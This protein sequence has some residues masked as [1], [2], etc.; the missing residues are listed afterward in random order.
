MK[1]VF[2][3]NDGVICL[4]KNWGSRF[5]KTKAYS[6][7]VFGL[8]GN[9]PV[10]FRFDNFDK[11]AIKVLNEILTETG[12]E[13]VVSSDWR[14]HATLEEMGEYYT[15]QGIIKKPIGLTPKTEDIDSK[16]WSRF[17][18][19]ALLED[20]RV[21]EIRY[22]LEHHPEVTHWVAVD[23]LNL[24]VYEPISGDIFNEDGLINFVHTRKLNEGIKQTGIKD[25][26]LN[27]LK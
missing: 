10:E 12:A 15:S 26:I 8:D 17:K 2:L 19:Q 22:W 16:W 27:F 18:N 3:D 14:H 20:E 1:V 25:K 23:D 21:I 5:K 6:N 24:G 4:P 7:V 11:K 13:I 9:I